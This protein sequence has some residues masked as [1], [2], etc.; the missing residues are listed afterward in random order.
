[1]PARLPLRHCGITLAAAGSLLTLA[2]CGLEF[3]TRAEARDE[4][5]RRY[6]LAQGGTLEI[7][8][9]NGRIQ[10][11]P[12]EGD[13][14]EIT[15]ERVVQAVDDEAAREALEA[16]EIQ[17]TVAD[18]R[19][20]INAAHREGLN[21]SINLNRRVSF[22]VRVPVWANLQLESTN[23]AIEIAGPRLAGALRAETTNGHIEAQGLEG[24]VWTST[25]NGA[26]SLQVS[27]LGS[28]GV[29]CQTTNGAIDL[30]VPPD[31]NARL[32]ARV[33]NGA[34]RANGLDLSV[35]SQSRRRL[36]ATIGIGGPPIELE[37][38]NGAIEISGR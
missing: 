17:E 5:Q 27:K 31:V 15:A 19:V 35:A 2:A 23:G 26:I 13:A 38:T 3:S 32:S 33:S 4:W 6:T 21:L 18:D 10:V 24:S 25:T 12:V 14:I 8:N 34:I 11:Q 30:V 28:E 37:T 7:R 20:S 1:M 16:F 36:D 29:S 9:T 22:Q